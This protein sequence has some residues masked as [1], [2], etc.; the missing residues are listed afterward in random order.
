MRLLC[1]IAL[2]SVGFVHHPAV[3]IAAEP[4]SREFAQYRLPDGSL[5]V[6]CTTERTPDGKEHGK[7]HMPGCEACRISAA[8]ILPA[9]QSELC[10]RLSYERQDMVIPSQESFRRELYPPNSGPRAPPLIRNPA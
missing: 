3:S 10:D 8:A 5:P 7:T 6:I 2:I 1:A 9:P 4:S